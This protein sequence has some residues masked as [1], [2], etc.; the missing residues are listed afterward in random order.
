[1]PLRLLAVLVSAALALPAA[2]QEV[3]WSIVVP[4]GLR[5]DLAGARVRAVL[6]SGSQ[7]A[8]RHTL[9]WDGRDNSGVKLAAGVYVLRLEA[10]GETSVRKVVVTR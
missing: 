9:R 4:E 3:G 7:Q 10:G 8:G 6:A 5:T 2:A 1:M